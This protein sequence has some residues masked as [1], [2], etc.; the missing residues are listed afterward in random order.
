[1]PLIRIELPE[2][3]QDT[4]AIISGE[5]TIHQVLEK[6]VSKFER[7]ITTA[8]RHPCGSRLGLRQCLEFA[9]RQAVGSALALVL[10]G[11]VKSTEVFWVVGP[12]IGSG[13]NNSWAENKLVP[14][15]L[16]LELGSAV[17]L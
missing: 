4:L 13:D 11:R 3:A 10:E 8:T 15:D 7:L 17:Q 9:F 12:G 16:Q 2:S 5:A 14:G 1:M 6:S